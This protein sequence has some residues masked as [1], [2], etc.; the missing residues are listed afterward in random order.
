[1]AKKKKVTPANTGLSIARNIN[2]FTASWK[3]ATKSV[4]SQGL[5]Y[6]TYDGT[7]WTDWTTP[8]ISTSATSYAFTL[9]SS[10]VA[11]QIQVQ[12]Q[13][14]RKG[15]TIS[16]W[17][18]SSAVFNVNVPPAPTLSVSNDTANRTTFSWSIETSDTDNAWYR[19][20]YYRT[21][22]STTPDATGGWGAWTAYAG[23]SLSYTDSTSGT[24]RIFQLKAMG[25]GGES[26]TRTERHYIGMAPLATWA[27]GNPVT[28]TTKGSYYEMV[29]KMKLSGSTYNVDS[30]VPQYCIGEPASD[31]S[32]PNGA[33]FTDGIAYTYSNGQ[34][35][36]ALTL[37]TGQIIDEDECLW[38]RI[39]TVHDSINSLS[40]PYRVLTGA[41]KAPTAT[42][43]PS[44]PTASGFSVSVNLTNTGTSVP[45]AYA[46]VFLEKRSKPGQENY[47]LLGTLPNGT[48]QRTITSSIDLTS[49]TGYAIHVRN[50]TA[51]G[52]S[53][54]SDYDSYSTS[55]PT[56]PTLNSVSNTAVAGK[57]YLTWTNSWSSATGTD[58]AW[59][60]DPDN[61]MSNDEPD[62]YSISEQASGWYITGLETGKVWYFRVRS[63]LIT[64][65]TETHTAW[66]NE[67]KIDLSSAPAVPTLYLSEDCITDDGMVTAYWSFVTTDGTPQS[68]GE[69]VTATYS[70]NTWTY[71]NPVAAVAEAQHMDIYAEKQG[72]TNGQMVYLALRTR[73]GSGGV[74]DYST[75]VK[76]TIA[77]KPTVAITN[78]GLTSGQLRALPMSVTVTTSSAKT[79]SLAIERATSYPFR[80]PD[81]T[82]TEGAI[83]ETVYLRTIPA[84]SSNSFSIALSNL[85]GR[86]DDG[87]YYNLVATVHD[88]YGQTATATTRF[89]VAWTHQAWVPSATFVSDQTDYFVTITPVSGTGYASGDTCDIYRVSADKPELIVEGATFGTAYVDPYPAF[90]VNSGYKLV[91]VTANGDYI[92]SANMIADYDTTD[93]EESTYVQLDPGLLVI[94]FGGDRI[95]LPYNISLG[96][97]W[98]KDFKRT[99]YLGG[100]VA[101]DHNKAVTR[102]LT[103]GTLIAR[104]LDEDTARQ[105]RE[106][107]NYP[108]ICHVRTP[109]GSSF[110]ADVQV[111]EDRNF[112]SATI[113][114]SLTI[115]K[116]DT[117]GFDGLTKA[118]WD[119]DNAE[120]E[121]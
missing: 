34:T 81:G 101:G 39:K 60:D 116:V 93:D 58:I 97:S 51:D 47:I 10:I 23:T 17:E 42:I 79:L 82:E 98:A 32:C 108:G 49:E 120:D 55:M 89:K 63:T 106:L 73:A 111:S 95:E 15:Y 117:V 40:A 115:Q 28:I 46:Q 3:I 92:T 88:D 83:G 16:A 109:E 18:S 62:I 29:C 104:N 37:A 110:A 76:L 96:N 70:N 41:L 6:R 54:V 103:A 78:A 31:M 84:A 72:W 4:K 119:A 27:N 100:H 36:Y 80:R 99:V 87:A 65:E 19:S 121:E 68:S 44:T 45:G 77:A 69:I 118:Q 24:T 22:C 21:K 94:D 12:T 48:T 85:M 8:T 53:M 11:K 38:V 74:S 2:T 91:T 113:D 5:R 33:N 1:M 52:H 114:Y 9:S 75:P 61:W 105:M 43:S 56:A 102:D 7:N 107:A 13:I 67:L 57:V 14:M 25:P 71:G 112:D 20:C 30:I 35:D 26:V 66:S 64:D 59:T 90:G 86:L 50:V